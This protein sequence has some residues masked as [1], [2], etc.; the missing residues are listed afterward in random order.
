MKN[1]IKKLLVLLLAV[2]C[3]LTMTL[4]ALAQNGTDS[5][6]TFVPKKLNT[7]SLGHSSQAEL[8]NAVLIPNADGKLL[9]FSIK[10]YN[11]GTSD[12]D[13]NSYWAKVRSKSKAGTSYSVK[14][15]AEDK[16]KAKLPAKNEYTI[17]YY[18]ELSA[19][20][21]LSDV[22]VDVIEWDLYSSSTSFEKRLGQFTFEENHFTVPAG[23]RFAIKYAGW[24]LEAGIKKSVVS[25]N[26]KYHNV[27]LTVELLNSGKSA[28]ALPQ[29][30]YYILTSDDLLYALTPSRMTSTE[31]APKMS[32]E[33]SLR[34]NIPVEVGTNNWK[35][36]VAN[37]AADN[38]LAL[39]LAT[40]EVPKS[41]ISISDDFDAE[42]SFATLDGLYY[43]TINEIT[44]SPI[45]E[46][47][48]LSA[49]LTIRNKGTRSVTVPDLQG[50]FVLDDAI[51]AP[52]TVYQPNKIIAITPNGEIDV[53]MYA[54][55]PYTFDFEELKLVLQEKDPV[56]N[57]T[58]NVLEV[59]GKNPVVAMKLLPGD[60][61]YVLKN[62][63]AR[64]EYA[65]REVR[66]YEGNATKRYTVQIDVK[67]LER[68]AIDIQKVAGYIKTNDGNIFPTEITELKNKITPAGRALLEIAA[69]LPLDY[70]MTDATLILGES[71]SMTADANAQTAYINPAEIQLPAD[72]E[73]QDSLQNIDLYPYKL[74]ISNVKSQIQYG[75]GTLILDFNY[76]LERNSLVQFSGE[77]KKIVIEVLDEANNVSLSNEYALEA[78]ENSFVVGDHDFRFENNKDRDLL[79]KI[80]RQGNYYKLNIYEQYG[81]EYKKLLASKEIR[82]FGT[83]D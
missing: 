30:K 44:R 18:S 32:E 49:N 16:G 4:T 47:D 69:T 43:V 82:W 77:N 39:P 46:Q 60:E 79:Y 70:D 74:S 17:T 67:N 29:L 81:T 38:Q 33:I 76:K 51:E 41:T 52:A 68:R 50:M 19:D 28:V 83:S 23:S 59:S 78:G 45:D 72:K 66:T 13:L 35:L 80:E 56:T 54:A 8:V 24:V 55:I 58:S 48:I 12:L 37:T 64:S 61:P 9:A 53:Y 42:Y 3:F 2:S 40:F 71:V 65:I 7:V 62:I 36:I 57:E 21:K 22:I 63:G 5:M 6:K 14:I 1:R 73:P 75:S 11:G 31:I 26:E 10:Y 15:I 34:A 20:A 25:S 27:A